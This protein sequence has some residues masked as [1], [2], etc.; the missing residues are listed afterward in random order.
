M[1]EKTL[2]LPTE[3]L[4]KTDQMCRLIRVVARLTCP[5]VDFVMQLICEANEYCDFLIVN[6]LHL[7]VCLTICT[8]QGCLRVRESLE[9]LYMYFFLVLYQS[10][11]FQLQNPQK[12][13]ISIHLALFHMH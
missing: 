9:Y 7:S 4:A 13:K 5:F 10:N 2:G 3:H 6:D 11:T 12:L 8:D 1:H